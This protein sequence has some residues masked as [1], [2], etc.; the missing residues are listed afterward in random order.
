MCYF[1]LS[2]ILL[3]EVS[4]MFNY[5]LTFGKFFIKLP[6]EVQVTI[7]DMPPV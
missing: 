7:L 5:V 6:L 3:L 4:I 2:K 1:Q